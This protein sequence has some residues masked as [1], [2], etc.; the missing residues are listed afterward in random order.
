MRAR[1]ERARR[2]SIL[3]GNGGL[4]VP[5]ELQRG[6]D[7]VMTGFA[8]P[9]M[10]AEVCRRHAGGRVSDAEDLFDHYLPLIRHEQQI[11]FGLAV[12]KEVL[13]RRGAIACNAARAPGPALDDDDIAELD[14]L[15]GRL[16]ARLERAGESIPDGI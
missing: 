1:R 10:L 13:R 11:G 5:Q 15:L 4:Y 7:G 14:H 16:R 3:T 6:A 9:G 12:R 8:F 2:L